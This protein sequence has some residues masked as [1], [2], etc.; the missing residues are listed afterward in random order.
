MYYSPQC[1]Y[2][3]ACYNYIFIH[4]LCKR[5]TEQP[6]NYDILSSRN[7]LTQLANTFASKM[8]INSVDILMYLKPLNI[9]DCGKTPSRV[10]TST[11]VLAGPALDNYS[12]VFLDKLAFIYLSFKSIDFQIYFN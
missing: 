9:H 1:T 3:N 4:K 7:T 5:K 8:K 11:V 12:N 10:K 2:T 6:Y